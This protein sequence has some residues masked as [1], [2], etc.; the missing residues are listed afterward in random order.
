LYV[1]SGSRTDGNEPGNDPRYSKEGETPLTACIWRIDPKADKPK[2]EVYAKGLR[3]AYG[4]CWNDKGEMLATENGPDA[5]PA[6]ELNL[7]EKGK[8]YGFP[9][10]FSDWAK[11]PYKHTPD[12]PKGVTFTRPIANLGPAAGGSA[13]KPLY[14]FDAHSSPSGI[15]Y[16]G[17][18]FPAPFRGGYFVAR[19]G[20]LLE[21]PRVGFDLLHMKLTK[22]AKGAYEAR[23]TSVLSP[24]AR[25][26]DL[27]LSGKGTVWVCEYSRQ[28]DNKGYAGMLPGRVVELRYTGG[29]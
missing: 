19:F 4:F 17:D 13:K 23:T 28:I 12:A 18:D 3:N 25:P 2:I 1:N 20:N 21:R 6:E 14:T 7:I 22:N 9:Y 27:H 29:K 11:K 15:V 24:I 8:H 16:L 5:D 10:Q 26:V